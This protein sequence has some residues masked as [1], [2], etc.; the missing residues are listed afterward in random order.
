MSSYL[1]NRCDSGFAWKLH[2]A[3]FINIWMEWGSG[4]WLWVM[5]CIYGTQ[6]QVRVQFPSRDLLVLTL[7]SLCHSITWSNQ[8][9]FSA[10]P[11]CRSHTDVCRSER[12]LRGSIQQEAAVVM[13]WQQQKSCQCKR[14]SVVSYY[15]LEIFRRMY[16][17]HQ[18]RRTPVCFS[19]GDR[20]SLPCPSDS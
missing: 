9:P 14:G 2:G 12:T 20:D 10:S 8:E 7:H 1:R 3:V 15:P 16:W 18:C 17:S 11:T 6:G 5:P 4:L 13:T 19:H